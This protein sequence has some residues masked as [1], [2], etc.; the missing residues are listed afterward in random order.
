MSSGVITAGEDMS[1]GRVAALM[2]EHGVKRLPVIR[3]GRLV[4]I[5]SRA[6]LLR[7]IATAGPN[8]TAPGDGAIRRSVL[9]RLCEDVGLDGDRIAVTVR[10]GIVHLS[11]SVG[12]D[13]EREAARV[14]VKTVRGV[15]GIDLNLRVSRPV[16]RD[17]TVRLSKDVK[18]N[19]K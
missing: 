4:G 8:A 2:E 9:T 7:A 5:V 15:D 19:G 10:A 1:V 6:D 17:G 18:E 13:A 14:A 11:G 3:D 16:Q 12:T